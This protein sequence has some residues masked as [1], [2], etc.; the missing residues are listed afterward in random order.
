M[1]KQVTGIILAGGKSNRMG[2]DKSLVL[3]QKKR[4]IEYPIDLLREFCSEILISSE[5]NK[6]TDY[7]YL[8]NVLF[9]RI[10]QKRIIKFIFFIGI[11]KF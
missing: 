10:L 11:K 1:N 7:E 5:T 2:K 6:L 4:L 8:V 3:Y 9:S